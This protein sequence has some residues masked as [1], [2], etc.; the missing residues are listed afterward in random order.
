MLRSI[1][2][3]SINAVLATFGLRISALNGVNDGIYWD[4]YVKGSRSNGVIGSEWHGEEI[5]ITELRK[6]AGGVGLEIGCGGGRITLLAAPIFQTLHAAD[7]SVQMLRANAAAV[8]ATNVQHHHL[9][10][11]DL[12]GFESN[13]M[14]CV[15]SHD[16]FV[17]FSS[18]QVYP[19]LREIH[20]VLKPGG[21]GLLSFYNFSR[22]FDLFKKMSMDFSSSRIYPPHMRVHFITQEMIERML[23]DVGFTLTGM[24]TQNFLIPVFRK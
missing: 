1:C 19:Y 6:N 3:D 15:F 14:D 23:V 24:D 5:F 12:D 7:V 20:R 9:N 21:V 18:L 13:S 8:Q 4:R 17:H 10:G 2:K 22:H 16:V 11:F